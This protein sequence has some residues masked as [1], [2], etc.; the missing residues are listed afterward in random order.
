MNSINDSDGVI[1]FKFHID[2]FRREDGV[3]SIEKRNE[4]E[5]YHSEMIIAPVK[6]PQ[7]VR[8]RLIGHKRER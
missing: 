6:F 3:K 2:A 5:R 4:I 8:D 1:I 7:N